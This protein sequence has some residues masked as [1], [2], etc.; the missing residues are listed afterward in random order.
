MKKI[1]LK[2]TNDVEIECMILRF[3][4]T[5]FAASLLSRKLDERNN[6]I[7]NTL[8]SKAVQTENLNENG[9]HLVKYTD[10]LVEE[11]ILE[12]L[13][14]SITNKELKSFVAFLSELK[15][16]SKLVLHSQCFK[17]TI[18]NFK[19]LINFTQYQFRVFEMLLLQEKRKYDEE[20]SSFLKKYTIM[21]IS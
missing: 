4:L 8:N 14:Y 6:D 1:F 10:H 18:S 16:E 2:E 5:P 17:E 13:K 3:N 12:I 7:L 21:F 15:E 19:K 11:F 20:K 9:S